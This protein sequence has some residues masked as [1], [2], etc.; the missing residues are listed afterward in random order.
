MGVPRL[1]AHPVGELVTWELDRY[2]AALESALGT[3]AEGSA[4]H[5]L[6]TMRLKAVTVEETARARRFTGVWR[7][8]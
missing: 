6:I 2:R 5:T 7:E 8:S 1:P 4:E 3:A